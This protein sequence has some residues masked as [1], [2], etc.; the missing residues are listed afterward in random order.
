MNLQHKVFSFIRKNKLLSA[1]QR[2]VVA[3]SGGPD[4]LCLLHVLRGLRRRLGITLIVAHL[5][6]RFREEAKNE[7]AAVRSLALKWRIP[8]IGA[9]IDV[10]RYVMQK[11]VSAQVGARQLRYRFLL[12]AARKTGASSIAVGH[13]YDDQVETV[14]LNIL[15]GTGPDGLA[16]MSPVR[17][18]GG[19]SL[20]R[21][22]LMVTRPEIESY[23]IQH[24][25]QPFM[26][27]SNKSTRYTRNR[28][29]LNLIPYLENHFNPRIKE[30]LIRLSHL[31]ALDRDY[32]RQV[33]LEKMKEIMTEQG[34]CYLMDLAG[35]HSLPE[36]LKGRV[37]RLVLEHVV[38]IKKINALQVERFLK[39][40]AG[41]RPGSRM[42]LPGGGE[43]YRDYKMLVIS[44][45]AGW[46]AGKLSPRVLQVPGITPIPET[47]S[48]IKARICPPDELVWPPSAEQAYLDYDCT[49]ERSLILRSRWPGARFHPLGMPAPVKLK[50]FFI[51]QKVPRTGRE[52]YPLVTAGEDVLWVVGLRPAHPYRV[53]EKTRN[54]LVLEYEKCKQE[55]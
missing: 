9:S 14:L 52:I 2:V 16:G 28:I 36:A 44:A 35:L 1:G 42:P 50:K 37:V 53:T 8:Y 33:S 25:L 31:T 51:S 7:A 3:V 46:H 10:P 18:L 30:A 34:G 21:P 43:V 39:L 45:N 13:H 48:V 6:H 38:P 55:A 20:I 15:R 32:L 41:A 26:D 5:N 17:N 40:A 4:S 49:G 22:L 54:V 19:V 27:A 47:G 23:C 12:Q 11:G 29:R 24:G